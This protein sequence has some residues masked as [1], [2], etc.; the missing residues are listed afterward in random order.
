MGRRRKCQVLEDRG[1]QPQ[2]RRRRVVGLPEAFANRHD[3]RLVDGPGRALRGRVVAA[4]GLHRVADELDAQRLGVAGREHVHDAAAHAELAVLVDGILARESGFDELLGQQE[5]ADIDPG[6][7][8]H[9][10]RRELSGRHQ[11][12]QQ[13]GRR[14]HDH[15]RLARDDL[16]QRA[17]AGGRDLQVRRQA[18]IRDRPRDWAAARRRRRRRPRPGPRAHRGSTGRPTSARRRRRRSA[19][20]RPSGPSESAV[21]AQGDVQPASRRGEARQGA[22][23]RV[24]AGLGGR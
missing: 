23:V 24:Q 6:R 19:R 12:R 11:P 21:G 20:R 5:R 17:R 10:R 8:V 14:D 7:Q 15:A 9:R 4:D 3:A 16:G 18:A 13:R 1:F 2:I 22:A